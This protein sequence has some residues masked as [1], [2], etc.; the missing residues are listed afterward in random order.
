MSESPKAHKLLLVLMR[1]GGPSS[2]KR[3]QSVASTWGQDLEEG[4]L[5]LLESNDECETKFGDNHQ[6]GLTC[7]EA[8]AHLKLMNR[9]DFDWLLVVDDDTYVFAERLQDTL[10]NMDVDRKAVYGIPGCG[11]CGHVPEK[12]GF[13]GGGGYMLS[14]RNLRRMAHLEAAPVA[15]DTEDE[16]LR[17]FMAGPDHG[18]WCDVRF[19]CVAQEAGLELVEVKGLYGWS[20]EKRKERR[21][22]ELKQDAPPLVLHYIKGEHM[23]LVRREHLKE[24]LRQGRDAAP[25]TTEKWLAL[26][27]LPRS[28][29][30]DT[31]EKWRDHL[32]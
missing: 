5:T 4:S 20:L 14:R 28:G 22:V 1:N 26:L 11:S 29:S 8:K 31:T 24:Q 6:E 7:L 10:R 30:P 16:F 12:R 3:L 19:G 9:T 21:I 13:C 25:Y 18:H 15:K 17:S 23:Q 2:P 32:M 27:A